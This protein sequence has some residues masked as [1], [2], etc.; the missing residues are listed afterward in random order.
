MRQFSYRFALATFA[1]ILPLQASAQLLCRQAL[2]PSIPGTGSPAT[3][4][5]IYNQYRE[6]LLT[7]TSR[8]RVR[9]S[10]GTEVP[11]VRS[12]EKEG[13][14]YEEIASW[15]PYMRAEAK[16]KMVAAFEKEQTAARKPLTDMLKDLPYLR[17]NSTPGWRSMTPKQRLDAIVA[18]ENPFGA[19]PLNF[20]S[21]LFEKS[22][23]N[24]DD[25]APGANTPRNITVG[26]DLG[27]Y[28]VRSRNG[29][30]S[31]RQFFE[32]RQAA[33][34]FLDGKVGHQHLFH[35]WP[36]DARLREEMAP[37]YI[38]LLD[39]TTWF[40]YWRQMKRNPEEVSSVLAHPY[41]GVYTRDSLNRLYSA[42]IKD[43]PEKFKD[44]FRMVGARSFKSSA[45]IPEQVQHGAHVPDWELR[46]G[47]KGAARDFVESILLSRLETGDYTA[48]RQYNSYEFNPSAPARELLTG[49]LD[50]A[51]IRAV[52]TFEAT[53]KPIE[54]STHTLAKNH[55]RNKVMSPLFPWANRIP[56]GAK[57]PLI[58]KLQREY[59]E[60]LVQVA[61][62]FA[63]KWPKAKNTTEKAE[64]NEETM[65]ALESLMFE[66]SSR[67]RLDHE[68]E[69]YLTPVPKELPSIVVESKGP[70]NVNQLKSGLEYSFRFPIELKPQSKESAEKEIGA[71]AERIGRSLGA[72]SVEK[73]VAQQAHGHG[74]SVKY[75]FADAHGRKW[76]VEWDGIQRTYVRGQVRNAWGGHVEIPTPAMSPAEIQ[77]ILPR[78]YGTAR[79]FGYTPDRKFGGAHYNFD[80]APLKALPVAQGTRAVTNLITYFETRSPIMMAIW[81]HPKRYRAAWPVE[82]RAEFLRTLEKFSG[83]W[84]DLGQMLY[85]QRYFNTGVGRKPKY[86][87]LNLTALMA[88]IVPAQFFDRSVDIRNPESS[89]TPD[90]ANVRDRGEARFFDAP[91][92][93]AT[94]SLQMKYWLA[95]LNK[96]FNHQGVMPVERPFRYEDLQQWIQDPVSFLKA[97]EAHLRELGLDP[98]EF[99]SVLWESYTNL[100]SGERMNFPENRVFP[101]FQRVGR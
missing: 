72:V 7:P 89:W 35:A 79:D 28:E 67:A 6:D 12:F 65:S 34:A 41:L 92:D 64:I 56:L 75:T 29:I 27:S 39:S 50:E 9:L 19:L 42:V 80:L 60:G 76:R 24:F 55:V 10:N 2:L 40:L 97:S 11:I 30:T 49:K 90:F 14:F 73:A 4:H 59:A 16:A 22:I 8:D 71:L 54:Y 43:Q 96:G 44:K 91:R 25:V 74:I 21:L 58:E 68:F 13:L 45:E 94:A 5:E 36:R 95:V 61:K 31:Q 78:L 48:L 23:I 87:P 70:V 38:E 1:L 100:L 33:E 32:E 82:P 98:I 15:F 52:E 57:T 26:D 83:D 85:N 63:V 20:K 86:V 18:L 99:Q 37:Y 81:T 47:N 3:A 62:D 101:E 51:G 46:S 77:S 69:R 17:G 53:Y 88:E 84:K 66:F 93:E